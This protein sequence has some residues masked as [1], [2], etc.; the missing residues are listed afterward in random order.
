MTAEFSSVLPRAILVWVAVL[1]LGLQSGCMTA[2]EQL[3]RAA[4][5]TLQ[6]GQLQAEVR[7]V[8][9]RPQRTE[10]GSN[11]KRLDFYQVTFFRKIP[12]NR[13]MILRS[14]C[15]LYDESASVEQFV[16]HVGEL[17]I[18]QTPM[19]WEAGGELD[20]ARV[21][22]IQR[23]TH[24]RDDLIFTFGTPTVEGLDRNG[25]AMAAWHFIK[26]SGSF[27]TTGHELLAVFDSSNR[28]KDYLLR[29]IRR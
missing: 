13:A 7:Q 22:G 4:V 28:V 25:D 27:F 24:S 26:G 8:F 12:S 5:A 18:W 6:K 10:T 14:L 21:R 16:H 20:E 3:D 29:E 17:P 2:G 11:G 15:V 23:E 19:G 9:G 1:V